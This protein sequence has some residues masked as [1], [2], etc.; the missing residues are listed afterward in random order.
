MRF[1]VSHLTWC[2]GESL[3]EALSLAQRANAAA[4]NFLVKWWRICFKNWG[5]EK[6]RNEQNCISWEAWNNFFITLCYSLRF[7]M[8]WVTL[9]LCLFPRDPVSAFPG[10]HFFTHFVNKETSDSLYFKEIS[11]TK[12]YSCDSVINRKKTL[13]VRVTEAKTCL[14]QDYG[15]RAFSQLETPVVGLSPH[16]PVPCS[17][18]SGC[19]TPGLSEGITCISLPGLCLC[20]CSLAGRLLICLIC[21][22][23]AGVADVYGN[24]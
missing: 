11:K 10:E 16:R 12:A 7:Q 24:F 17:V 21:Q 15:Y 5:C 2:L 1:L 9:S 22:E 4:R 18:K 3:L 8:A 23:N 14:R 19:F 13:L 20:S 6:W